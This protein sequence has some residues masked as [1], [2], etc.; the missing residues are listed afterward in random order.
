MAKWEMTVNNMQ[1]GLLAIL[2]TNASRSAALATASRI[3]A[4]TE[5]GVAAGQ[6]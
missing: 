1:P 3:T 5:A 6:S 4:P 2:Y